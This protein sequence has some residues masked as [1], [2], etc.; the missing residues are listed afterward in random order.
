MKKELGMSEMI[1]QSLAEKCQ[2]IYSSDIGEISLVKI[3][4]IFL[5]SDCWEIYCLEGDLFDDDYRFETKK[6]AEIEIAK[7]LGKKGEASV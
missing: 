1:S 7:F 3:E 5:D 2:Y 6:E 4:S